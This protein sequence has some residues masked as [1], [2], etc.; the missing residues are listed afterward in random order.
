M[1]KE[2]SE[3][4][5]KLAYIFRNI[6]VCYLFRNEEVNDHAKRVILRFF[7]VQIDNLLK[8]AGRAK[9]AL[10]AEGLV[11]K[12]LR[13]MLQEK[14]RVLQTDFDGWYSTIRDKLAA[15]SQALD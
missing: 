5:D 1:R 10:V 15:H 9:N 14:I 2:T 3:L 4:V 13:N 7:F 6:D 8:L 11:D 12:Q